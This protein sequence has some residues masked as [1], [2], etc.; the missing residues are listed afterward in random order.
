MKT[1]CECDYIDADISCHQCGKEFKHS[2]LIYEY[3]DD[4]VILLCP[5][6]SGNYDYIEYEK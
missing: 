4:T 2:E 1:L 3:E 5:H 6:C